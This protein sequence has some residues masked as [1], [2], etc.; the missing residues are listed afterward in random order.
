VFDRW[1]PGDKGMNPSGASTSW[2]CARRKNARPRVTVIAT[3]AEEDHHGAA[4][5][6]DLKRHP[7]AL[8]QTRRPQRRADKRVMLAAAE[9]WAKSETERNE[10]SSRFQRRLAAIVLSSRSDP[11]RGNRHGMSFL[12][13]AAQGRIGWR[14]R[15]RIAENAGHAR[16]DGR[17]IKVTDLEGKR[18]G[19]P[20]AIARYSATWL[21]A[22][23]LAPGS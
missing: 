14:T 5:A 22:I 19:V 3:L 1:L 2:R 6:A 10:P 16:Q 18:T 11:E 20:L 23:T 17:G 13:A 12:V 8:R 9:P 15:R 4:P 21:S 7:N